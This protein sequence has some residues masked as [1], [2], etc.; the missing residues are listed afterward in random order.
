MLNGAAPEVEAFVHMKAGGVRL[1]HSRVNLGF[2]GGNNRAAECARGEYLVLLNDD[3]LVE[4]GWLDW[5]VSAADANPR[6]G[7]VGSC[8]L[9]SDGRIQEAGSLIWS[10]GSTMPVARGVE[11][12]SLD[13][14]FA[15]PVDYASAC[16]LLV[17]R[18][19]W[20]AVG[21]LDEGYYPA[22]YEDVDLCLAIR[23]ITNHPARTPGSNASCLLA[24]R[25]G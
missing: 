19:T 4:P 16:S 22:Y 18:N 2:A 12:E 17:R 9:F 25:S 8:V 5:L 20:E 23:A 14:H 21:G 13:W 24:I 3:T 11:S 7:A 10:D 6:A 1:A 15:R